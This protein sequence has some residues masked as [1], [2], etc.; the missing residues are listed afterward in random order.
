MTQIRKQLPLTPKLAAD[1]CG[2]IDDLLDPEFFKGFSD[3]T[4][5][6]L[7]ACISKC[8]RSC[9]VSEV[10]DC[11]SVDFSVVSRHLALLERA[12][13][14]ES[15]KVGRTVFYSVKYDELAGKLRALADALE[16]YR[17][18]SK[19]DGEKRACCAR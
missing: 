12:G 2:P 10:A 11:C 3:P 17:P 5:L 4:R 15:T 14:V 8:G 9:S 13:I 1:C 19:Y 7:L 18:A 16:S 6:N